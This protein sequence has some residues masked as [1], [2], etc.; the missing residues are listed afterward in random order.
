MESLLLSP[1]SAAR[2]VFGW[3]SSGTAPGSVSIVRAWDAIARKEMEMKLV[4]NRLY[5][6]VSPSHGSST[7]VDTT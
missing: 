4:F 3:Y 5:L 7:T 2:S 1:C 6:V